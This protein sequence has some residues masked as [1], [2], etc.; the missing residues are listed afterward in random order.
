M[1]TIAVSEFRA[2]LMAVLKTIE[3]GAAIA[4]TSRG[5]EIA[6]LMPPED[7][8]TRARR[9]LNRLRKTAIIKDVL[10][11]LQEEWEASK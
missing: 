11:P 3:G 1:K 2:N 5:R 10:S 6:R 7:S 4:I 8:M 9:E